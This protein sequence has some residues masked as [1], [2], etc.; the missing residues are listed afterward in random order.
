MIVLFLLVVVVV[1]V[2]HECI[3]S[4]LQQSHPLLKPEHHQTQQVYDKKRQLST[5]LRVRFDIAYIS[6]VSPTAYRNTLMLLNT[7][8]ILL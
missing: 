4:H 5:G 2:S 1:V 3:H 8:Q 7:A 6:N